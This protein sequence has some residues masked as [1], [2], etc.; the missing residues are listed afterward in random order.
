MASTHTDDRQQLA[1]VHAPAP[2]DKLAATG[3][4]A[5]DSTPHYLTE[6]HPSESVIASCDNVAVMINIPT[7]GSFHPPP[8]EYPDE[9]GQHYRHPR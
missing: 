3:P 7:L 2:G 8:G 4:I 9:T 1:A 6:V 5:S